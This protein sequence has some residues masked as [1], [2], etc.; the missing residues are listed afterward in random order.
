MTAERRRPECRHAEDFAGDQARYCGIEQDPAEDRALRTGMDAVHPQRVTLP[1]GDGQHAG[2][3]QVRGREPRDRKPP[4]HS[5]RRQLTANPSDRRQQSMRGA[6]TRTGHGRLRWPAAVDRLPGPASGNPAWSCPRGL[7]AG[8]LTGGDAHDRRDLPAA[9]PQGG[10]T[11]GPLLP[12]AGVDRHRGNGKPGQRGRGCPER[13]VA[14]ISLI[15]DATRRGLS[16]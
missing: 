8:H 5:Y 16:R 2:K 15:A 9:Q 10:E 7:A 13:T 1:A 3:Q 11:L 6:G 14:S 12:P 4:A